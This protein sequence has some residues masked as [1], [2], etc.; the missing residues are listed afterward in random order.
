MPPSQLTEHGK[1]TGFVYKITNKIN[2]KIYIG[3]TIRSIR[4]RWNE[5]CK[6]KY[7]CK[8]LVK[9]I[10]KY[11]KNNFKV[12]QIDKANSIEELNEKEIFWISVY[13]TT[14]RNIGY[15]IEIGGL[16]KLINDKKNLIK[17]RH[18]S[19][20][21]KNWSE[22]LTGRKK[23]SNVNY[24]KKKSEQHCLN[25]S[26]NCHTRRTVVQLDLERNFIARYNTIQD[27]SITTK[28]GRNSISACCVGRTKTG[29]KYIWSYESVWSET[30]T[31][32]AIS[33]SKQR[34]QEKLNMRHGFY[35]MN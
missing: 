4:I 18:P 2:G 7:H 22:H 24:K 17:R 13:K 26:K 19:E 20:V 34:I 35:R 28:I 27:A 15:N 25:I 32:D 29:G 33:I 14:N 8:K 11:G 9:A 3:Q 12:D 31:E 6:D 5:H 1:K 30:T 23:W 16:N 21:I 10:S